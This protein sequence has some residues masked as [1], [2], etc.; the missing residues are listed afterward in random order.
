MSVWRMGKGVRR[1]TER[2]RTCERQIEANTLSRL[3][4]IDCARMAHCDSLAIASGIASFQL[5]EQA[6]RVVVSALC[7]RWSPRPIT[8]LCGPGNNGGDGYALGWMLRDLGWPVRLFALAAPVTADAHHHARGWGQAVADLADFQPMPGDLVVD[9]LFGAGLTRPLTGE[10]LRALVRCVDRQAILVAVDV[11]SGLHGDTGQVWGFAAPACLTVTFA[12]PKPGHLLLPGRALCGALVVGDIG[13]TDAMVTASRPNCWRNDPALWLLPAPGL[14][15]HK[16]SRGHVLLI[17]SAE[18]SGAIRLAARAARRAG[19]GLASVAAP[20]NAL[21]LYGADQP[22]LLLRP[23][24][25]GEDVAALLTDGRINQ[26][27]IGPGLGRGDW[28]RDCTEAALAAARP[29]VLDADLFSLFADAPDQLAQAIRAPTVLTPHLGE[30]ERVF[31]PVAGDRIAAVRQASA[32]VGAVIVLKGADSIIAHPDGRVILND[33]ASPYLATAG[34][35][36]VLAGTIAGLMAQGVPVF[37]A[38]AAGVWLHGAAGRHCGRGLI[39]EDLADA[40]PLV[41]PDERR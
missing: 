29:A 15:D 6:A 9:A 28:A 5:M 23:I 38:A 30:F 35:G 26:L 20:A 33:H 24:A 27:V 22:G 7:N 8:I 40:L 31:G 17:G 18:T 1:M 37:D 41:W 16:F 2:S 21:P 19:V 14:M 13:I 36:D 3:A 11:P 39:A 12:R 25:G 10:A 32:A 34:S 4:I